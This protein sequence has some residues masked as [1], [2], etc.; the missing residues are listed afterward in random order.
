MRLVYGIGDAKL[1]EYGDLILT[2]LRAYCADRGLPMDQAARPP[3][4]DQPAKVSPP[5]GSRAV[6]FDLFREKV[7]VEDVMDRTS[8]THSTVMDYL[9]DFIRQ[10]NVEDISAWVPKPLYDQVAAAARR[11]GTDRLKPLFEELREKVPYDIIRLVV[12]HMTR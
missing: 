5:T 6:A 9:A 12:A 4:R 1:R 8:R 10:E 3:R 2:K 11:V 7:A